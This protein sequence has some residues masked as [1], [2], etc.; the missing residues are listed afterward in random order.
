MH[1]PVVRQTA[2]NPHASLENRR[3]FDKL[4]V[5]CLNVLGATSAGK[6]ALLEAMLPRLRAELSVGVV[7]AD[8]CATCDAERVSKCGVPVVQVLTDGQCYLS[9]SQLQKGITELPLPE[10]DL[11][12]VENIGNPICPARTE[13]GAHAKIAVFCVT[14]GHDSLLKYPQLAADAVLILLNKYD[15]LPYVRFDLEAALT[16]LRR[17]NPSAEI[18]CTST[19]SRAGIDRAAGWLSG[20]VRAQRPQVHRTPM[21]AG[22]A[23]EANLCV[24]SAAAPGELAGLARPFA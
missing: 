4:G 14:G 12:L 7:E 13:I 21:R 24:S 23:P 19:R 6:T 10:I 5:V 17:L 16:Y 11:L 3:V 2:P 1:V 9:A 18:V 20:Y 22:A 15:L 8:L